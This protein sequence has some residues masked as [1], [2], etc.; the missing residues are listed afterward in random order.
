MENTNNHS[1]QAIQS[2]EIVST[3]NTHQSDNNINIKPQT[4]VCIFARV[5]TE[6]QDND[7]QIN[8]LQNYVTQKGWDL[9]YTIANNI[10]GS[11]DRKKRPDLEE[12]LEM[13]EKGVF[14]KVLVSELSRISRKAKI[15]RQV[16]TR[17]HELGISVVFKNLGG[18]ESIDEFG[19]ETFVTNIIISIYSEL[20]QE[21]A[22]LISERVKSGIQNARQNGQQIGR[23]KGDVKSKTKLYDEYSNVVDMLLNGASLNECISANNVSKN[24]IIKVKRSLISDGLMNFSKSENKLDANNHQQ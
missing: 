23:K 11:N 4:K 16:L 21:E 2:N 20:A 12:L 9:T 19:R 15:F 17:L 6:M 8:E 18:L 7:R 22:R 3:N 1:L 24:T 10:S 14:Q 5:S 13:A